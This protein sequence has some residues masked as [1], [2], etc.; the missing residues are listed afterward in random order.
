MDINYNHA[1]NNCLED[2]I[3]MNYETIEDYIELCEDEGYIKDVLDITSNYEI[4]KFYVVKSAFPMNNSICSWYKVKI[5]LLLTL[6]I[7]YTEESLLGQTKVL[8]REKLL[9]VSVPLP[10]NYRV[11]EPLNIM[12]EVVDISTKLLSSKRFYISIYLKTNVTI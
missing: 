7:E 5:L 6:H 10:E 9:N 4:K 1:E 8:S 3:S 2:N 11:G 12:P